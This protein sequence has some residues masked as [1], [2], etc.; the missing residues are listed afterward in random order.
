MID[1]LVTATFSLF[2]FVFGACIGSFLNVVIYRL[3]AQLSLLYPPS[4]CPHCLHRLGTLENIPIL[5]W[6]G[7]KGK[8]RWC[9]APISPRYPLIETLTGFIFLVI[10]WQFGTTLQTVGYWLFLSWLVALTFIDFD[11]LTLPN[12]LLKWGLITGLAFQG[13]MGWP[14]QTIP[15]HLVLGIGSAVLGLWLFDLIR[16]AGTLIFGQEAMGDGDPPL[17]AMIGAWLGW[18]SLLMT[19]FL[20]CSI[21]AILGGGAITLKLISRKTPIPFGPFLALGA[22]LAV[23]WGQELIHWYSQIFLPV[24]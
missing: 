10:F 7:L 5:G 6:L 16:Y 19:A 22:A 9:H 12:P 11:T 8:C 3:P 13:V 1:L 18:K 21:G 20:A 4:R 2:T 24:F 17:A 15:Q 14:T 23:V